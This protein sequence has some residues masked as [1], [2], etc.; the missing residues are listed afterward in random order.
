MDSRLVRLL[1]LAA[2]C[3]AALAATLVCAYFV[4][5]AQRW[6]AAALHGLRALSDHRWVWDLGEGTAHSAD[7]GLLVP[8]VLLLAVA[9]AVSNRRR[10]ALAALIL[11]AGANL[12]TQLLKVAAAHPRYQSVLGDHQLAA[13]AFPSGHATGAMSLALA[14]VLVVP[15]RHRPL[16]AILGGLYALAVGMALMIQG[17]HFP[18]DVLAGFLVAGTAGMLALAGLRAFGGRRGRV[19]L[20][21]RLSIRT[22]GARALQILVAVI[23]VG[24]ALAAVVFP[25]DLGSYAAAHTSGVIASIGIAAA[26]TGLI[27][28]LTAELETAG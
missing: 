16:A 24:A 19:S 21:P 25:G 2:G 28:A 27:F 26:A 22:L 18:S 3:V 13:T 8:A 15:A 12:V 20:A 5:P 7:P 9:G 11:V 6:D 17:W 14:G 1:G 23:A 4:A 10:Q